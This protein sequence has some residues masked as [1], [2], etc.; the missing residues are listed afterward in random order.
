MKT[1][2]VLLL[3]MA[4]FQAFAETGLK[5]VVEMQQL[6]PRAS[7]ELQA[8]R[9]K[10]AAANP[11]LDV[12]KVEAD[13]VRRAVLAPVPRTTPVM[14]V[15][16]KNHTKT[17]GLDDEVDGIRDRLAAEVSGLGFAVMDSA[18]IGAAFNRF[19][20][21]TKEER[22]GLIDGLFTGG[23]VTRTAQ[24]L[25]ADYILIAS[26]V[27]A[28]SVR[29]MAGDRQVLVYTLRMTTKVLDATTGASVYGKNWS[30]K[31][32]TPVQS[33][34]EADDPL[35]HYNDLIDGWVSDIGEELAEASKGWRRPTAD[36]GV[37]ASFTVT[38]T[39][40]DVFRPLEA[41][42]DASKAVKEELRV[43]A[44]GCTV[45]IDGAAVGCS[46]GRFKARPG[47][48]QM[49]VTRQWMKPWSG[50]VNIA[51]GASFNVALE[52]SEEGF[53]HYQN[54]EKLRAELALSYAEA[55]FRRGCRVTFDSSAWHDVT[56]TQVG[57][58][59]N[60]LPVMPVIQVPKVQ[61][62]E[63]K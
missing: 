25:G 19:K 51:D 30:N 1:T 59:L 62:S 53:K 35:V 7:A 39:L 49:R 15:F 28:S 17:R 2:L 26:V 33:D 37:L 27:G 60:V 40:D 56:L 10:V 14:A 54:K 55:A 61:S 13:V 38:T 23:S 21:T 20:I 41:T 16:V 8:F 48:H 31:Q 5:R 3:T 29:R 24:M 22:D 6:D 12:V 45:E 43:V 50:T 52:L 63:A 18:E 57:K 42:V 34:V 44:G 46:G 36:S 11:G 9:E 58:D 32:P 4:V 47:V